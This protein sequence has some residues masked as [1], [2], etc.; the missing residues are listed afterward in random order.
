MSRKINTGGLMPL[1][2]RSPE[3][4][5]EI[6]RKG[7]IASGEARRAKRD[8]LLAFYASIGYA[9]SNKKIAK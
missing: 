3:E 9:K 1:M 5:Q 4:R 8:L 7:G 6:A 2:T